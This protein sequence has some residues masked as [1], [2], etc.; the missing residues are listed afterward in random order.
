MHAIRVYKLRT[1]SSS[2]P[3]PQVPPTEALQQGVRG[4]EAGGG[5]AGG[6]HERD[7]HAL[8]GLRVPLR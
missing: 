4:R 2:S 7:G 1:C 5:G 8:R 3:S 6:G